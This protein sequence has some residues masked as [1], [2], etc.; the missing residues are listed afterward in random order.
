MEKQNIWSGLEE[1]LSLSDGLYL[2]EY[3]YL[4]ENNQYM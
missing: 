2:L 1:I 3:V 4:Y